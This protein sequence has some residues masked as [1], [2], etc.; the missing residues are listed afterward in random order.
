MWLGKPCIATLLILLPVCASALPLAIDLTSEVRQAQA[1]YR[2]RIVGGTVEHDPSIIRWQAV[3]LKGGRWDAL[4]LLPS[5]QLNP[6]DD[7]IFSQQST[8][9]PSLL[10]YLTFSFDLLRKLHQELSHAVEVSLRSTKC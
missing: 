10:R 6:A 3:F 1:D 8:S 2:P 5:K 4:Y 9:R 7:S